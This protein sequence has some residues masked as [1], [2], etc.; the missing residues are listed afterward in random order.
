MR[1]VAYRAL[2][3]F[4]ACNIKSWERGPGDEARDIQLLGG[5]NTGN[6]QAYCTMSAYLNLCVAFWTLF[7]TACLK[8]KQCLAYDSKLYSAA[9]MWANSFE[10][11]TEDAV[12]GLALC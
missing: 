9:F 3:P 7:P 5:Y 2:L 12:V 10:K 8:K 1:D 4:F 6:V 11:E